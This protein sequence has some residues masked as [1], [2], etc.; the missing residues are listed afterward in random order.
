[1]PIP[2]R[3]NES[4]LARINERFQRELGISTR[5][6]GGAARTLVKSIVDALTGTSIV[7]SDTFSAL[8]VNNAS[9][10]LLDLIGET[11]NL[12]RLVN[13]RAFADRDDFNVVVTSERGVLRAQL[14]NVIPANVSF[15]DESGTKKFVTTA[16]T[17]VPED[18]REVAVPV[19]A[20]DSGTDSNLNAGELTQHDLGP[21]VVV[22][23]RF[24]IN[25]GLSTETDANF[26]SRILLHMRGLNTG[27]ANSIR[28]ALLGLEGVDDV[29]ILENARGIGTVGFLLVPIG[30]IL[31]SQTLIGARRLASSISSAGV[32]PI[33]L[34]PRYVPVSLEAVLQFNTR[35]S[36][37]DIN[38]LTTTATNL[39]LQ[40]VATVP[41]GGNFNLQEAFRNIIL[42]LGDPVINIESICFKANGKK[43]VSGVIRL[44]EDQLLI[45]ANINK[46]ITFIGKG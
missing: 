28:A 6:A 10:E 12:R 5:T 43:L 41:I 38:T 1:M 37:A 40:E 36:D 29:K 46:P 31:P 2:V 30:N 18:A 24:P 3:T 33:I 32:T 26:R 17:V 27:N 42:A 44:E 14:G 45:P 19:V 23:N 35:P 39:F 4:Q 15:R 21:N 8:L 13:R 20:V 34:G 9:G 22:T 25:G 16:E 11:Y 7:L